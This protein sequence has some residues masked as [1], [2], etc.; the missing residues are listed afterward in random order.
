MKKNDILKSLFSLTVLPNAEKLD[1]S[2][3]KDVILLDKPPFFPPAIGWWI[4]FG[5]LILGLL[6]FFWY[7]KK[8][9]FPSPYAYAIYEL[10]NLKKQNLSPVE[11]GV[12]IS[13][14]LKRVAI[15]KYGRETVSPLADK[16]WSHFL[17]E[18]GNHIFSKEEANFIAKSAWMPPKKDIAIDFGCLYTHTKAWIQY[19][20]K[21]EQK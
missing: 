3:M 18:K 4:V 21:R 10:N 14:L 20:L 8:R 2:G 11:V 15:F 16:E 5:L 1:L 17:L 13:K 7:V 19:T 12:S 6:V 9:Y